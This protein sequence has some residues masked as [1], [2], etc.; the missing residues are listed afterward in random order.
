M[1]RYFAV[2]AGFS[3]LATLFAASGRADDPQLAP[4]GIGLLPPPQ[5]PGTLLTS[6]VAHPFLPDPSGGFSR[7][8]F[9]TD[10]APDF[11]I[12]IRDYSFPAGAAPRT[13]TL[14][15]GSLLHVLHGAGH[16]VVGTTTLALATAPRAV[17]AAG[18][19]V[20]ITSTGAHPLVLRVVSLEQK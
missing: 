13:M 9:Q 12:V 20:Q 1:R 11:R 19:A 2:I 7:V 18:T 3:I 17:A 15:A 6:N 10:A 4:E 8:V 5:A 14:P 16:V